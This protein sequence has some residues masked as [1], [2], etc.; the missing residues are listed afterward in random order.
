MKLTVNAD[1]KR[2]S[3]VYILLL[4]ALAAGS[5]L[6]CLYLSGSWEGAGDSIKEYIRIVFD[7]TENISPQYTELLLP[8][9]IAVGIVFVMGFFRFGFIVTGA[10]V[11]RK[12]FVAGFTAASFIRAYGIRGLLGLLSASPMTVVVMPTLI[13]YSAINQYFLLI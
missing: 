9:I 6:G 2:G 1:E 7:G 10:V 4:T 11:I 8:W 13:I 3:V 12:G 5:V